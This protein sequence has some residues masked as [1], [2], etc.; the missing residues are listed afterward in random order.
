MSRSQR[1][2]CFLLENDSTIQE[3]ENGERNILVG[4]CLLCISF[5][6]KLYF[7]IYKDLYKKH[8]TLPL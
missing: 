2:G 6:Q 7:S 8:L 1:Y 4:T 5:Q 3:D